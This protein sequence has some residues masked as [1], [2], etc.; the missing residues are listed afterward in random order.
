MRTAARTPAASLVTPAL[1]VGVALFVAVIARQGMREVGA[2]LAVAGPGL[3]VVALFHLVPLL[4]DALGW[5]ALL[6][7]AIRP[8]V[9]AMVLARW[10]AEAV[11][12]LLPVLQIGGNV[13][14]ARLLIRRGV[15]GA[16]VGAS[17]VV[18]MTLV[19]ATQVVF[20]LVGLAL[21]LGHLG[22]TRLTLAAAAGTAVTGLLLAV[23]L[24]VQR[25]QPFTSLARLSEWLAGADRQT[26]NAGAV[27]LDGGVAALYRDR[28][29]IVAALAWHLLAW[30]VGAGEVWLALHFLGHPVPLHTAVLLE[31]LCQA[32]R[33]GAFFVPGALGVQEGGF[34]LL[35][36]ALGLAPDTA[37]A[38]SL[39]RRVRD[40][41]LGVPGLVF[42]QLDV[43][44]RPA[45]ASSGA[46]PS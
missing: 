2:A 19:V 6:A 10:V 18:D 42:W 29:A 30:F 31:S 35:G 1:F 14:R 33:T 11:N 25:R 9:G 32:V 39:T 36:G 20:T 43:A 24:L 28:G 15:P 40:L 16:D 3:L 22:F 13:A 45:Q 44:T 26:F 5:R 46:V 37:L 21:L 8:S 12:G 23:V 27:A 4:G 34:L 41:V 7:P 38:L 17:V